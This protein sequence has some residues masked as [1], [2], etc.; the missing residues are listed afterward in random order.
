VCGVR[1]GQQNPRYDDEVDWRVHDVI[2]GMMMRWTGESMM[3]AFLPYI[4]TPTPCHQEQCGHGHLP[5]PATSALCHRL[6]ADAACEAS[7]ETSCTT[8]A[9]GAMGTA[10]HR[11][12]APPRQCPAT[13]RATGPRNQAWPAYDAAA[14]RDT[15]CGGDWCPPRR[16]LAPCLGPTTPT[17]PPGPSS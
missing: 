14:R 9:T 7:T 10:N 11:R 6:G 17:S 4:K 3:S 1:P 15:A 5:L 13:S 16:R 2:L 8:A 12:A